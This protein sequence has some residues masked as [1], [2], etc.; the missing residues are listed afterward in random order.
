MKYSK[1]RLT[2]GS[3]R[4]EGERGPERDRPQAGGDEQVV[5]EAHLE[6]HR[7]AE[8]GAASNGG[9]GEGGHRFGIGPGHDQVRSQT[10]REQ[11][12]SN[13]DR[14]IFVPYI[15]SISWTV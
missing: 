6:L 10:G 2:E 14:V 15:S 11:Q 5:Q 1:D 3:P 12:G 13:D 4:S 9:R 8:S 7:E